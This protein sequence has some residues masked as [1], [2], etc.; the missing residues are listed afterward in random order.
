MHSIIAQKNPEQALEESSDG[1]VP[2][3]SAHLEETATEKVVPGANH[4]NVVDDPRCVQEILRI[5]R[6]H[7]GS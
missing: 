4:Q 2:Y 5:L 7:A 3:R 1:V 6:R